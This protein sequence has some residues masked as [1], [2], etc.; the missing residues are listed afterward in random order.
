MTTLM[1]RNE[2]YGETRRVTFSEL[3]AAFTSGVF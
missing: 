1:N 3:P 2:V